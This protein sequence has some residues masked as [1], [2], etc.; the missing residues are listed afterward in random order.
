[1]YDLG[2]VAVQIIALIVKIFF[3]NSKLNVMEK[4][5]SLID[6]IADAP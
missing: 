6:N 5:Y 4:S 3:L 1:M 2:E